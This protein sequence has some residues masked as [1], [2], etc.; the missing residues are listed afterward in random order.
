MDSSTVKTI[1]D[2]VRGSGLSLKDELAVAELVNSLTDSDKQLLLHGVAPILRSVPP[3]DSKSVADG[4][5]PVER[6]IAEAI[7]LL[8]RA[9]AAY[10]LGLLGAQAANLVPAMIEAMDCNLANVGDEVEKA[11]PKIGASYAVPE[12]LK[13]LGT[14]PDDGTNWESRSQDARIVNCFKALGS[15]GSSAACR[16]APFLGI[17]IEAN[18]ALIS[19]GIDAI[20]PVLAEIQRGDKRDIN[21]YSN[22]AK[23]L[24][25][26]G[27]EG[28]RALDTLL[29]SDSAGNR[30][31]LRE[32]SHYLPA[33]LNIVTEPATASCTESLVADRILEGIHFAAGTQITVQET[34]GA[35]TKA[36]LASNTNVMGITF[37]G[38][39]VLTFS[40][41]KQ[42]E[43]LRAVA[44]GEHN[45]QGIVLNADEAPV[46]LE[47]MQSRLQLRSV[48]KSAR[49][50]APLMANGVLFKENADL[51]SYRPGHIGAGYLKKETVID[52]IAYG[53]RLQNAQTPG[54]AAKG[55]NEH[56][57]VV[58]SMEVHDT[59]APEVQRDCDIAFYP[60]GSVASG[61]LSRRQKVQ[62]LL[63]E[64]NCPVFFYP[65]G[66]LFGGTLAE[67]TVISDINCIGEFRLLQNGRLSAGIL[68]QEQILDGL[69]CVVQFSLHAGGKLRGGTLAGHQM[70]GRLSCVGNFSL[71]ENGMPEYVYL[72]ADDPERGHPY[73]QGWLLRFGSD[74]TLRGH[75][76]RS[77]GFW[78]TES[79]D[80][81][82]AGFQDFYSF[83]SRL[84]TVCELPNCHCH[85]L[86][87]IT[88]QKFSSEID[89][90]MMKGYALMNHD[91][92]DEAEA[93]QMKALAL[94]EKYRHT[95]GG[96]HLT[97][98]CTSIS[99]RLELQG[100][101]DEALA[102][103]DRARGH[104]DDYGRQLPGYEAMLSRI[105]FHQCQIYYKQQNYAQLEVAL[106]ALLTNCGDNV[107]GP[108]RRA[109]QSYELRDAERMLAECYTANGDFEGAGIH[110]KISLVADSHN[111]S[112][113]LPAL[114]GY[115][116][117]LKKTGQTAEALEI[118]ARI[119]RIKQQPHRNGMVCGTGRL[120]EQ[121]WLDWKPTLDL[122]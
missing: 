113:N 67:P 107:A 1:V 106:V 49:S 94:A 32:V 55:S 6:Q 35:L 69:R 64:A 79:L 58:I 68:A 36:V 59:Q 38:G 31:A 47:F 122:D 86:D 61:V 51:V 103:L 104:W 33:K 96:D 11:L 87:P 15:A 20:A 105:E 22:A 19:M 89:G 2:R 111:E 42:G 97:Q 25:G 48:L 5:K 43:L 102:M 56:T 8:Q 14:P 75:Q 118:A 74:G 65:D 83:Y 41:R 39:A 91:R 80:Y 98:L 29:R 21:V 30:W 16:V 84:A 88:P 120:Q 17:L 24:A 76:Q 115:Y 53:P 28:V 95:F 114:E 13:A 119:E 73:N 109:L 92:Y 82:D 46:V 85:R 44:T 121:M 26:I 90:Y 112:H 45:V 72:A 71:H 3:Q 57:G 27:S 108:H 77:P 99:R 60:G 93:V 54:R 34:D 100:R 66:T 117:L 52:R 23:V 7:A 10:V 62:G 81:F 50:T 63:L 116:Q 37:A 110:Y 70:I 9:S 4:P 101:L 40:G 78:Q 12:L 18:D